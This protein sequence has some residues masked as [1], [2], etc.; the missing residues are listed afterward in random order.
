MVKN[1]TNRNAQM[2]NKERIIMAMISTLDLIV[3]QQIVVI[4]ATVIQIVNPG[5]SILVNV[6]L[7]VLQV[8]F[9]IVVRVPTENRHLV[10][11]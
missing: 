9:K 4:Y 2:S 3:I 7:R 11:V 1:L 6:I 8:A 10:V 5:H